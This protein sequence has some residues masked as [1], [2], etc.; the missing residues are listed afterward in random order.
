VLHGDRL[1]LAS[2]MQPLLPAARA[3]LAQGSPADGTTV[4]RRE[5]SHIQMRWRLRVAA[6]LTESSW[7][8]TPSGPG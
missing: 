2:S 8:G 6:E 3:L 4:V 5:V 7:P 1:L